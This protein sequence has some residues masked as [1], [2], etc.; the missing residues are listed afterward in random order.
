MILWACPFILLLF[1]FQ[2][3]G[4]DVQQLANDL[5]HPDVEVRMDAANALAD[6]GPDALPA[7][8]ALIETLEDE[9]SYVR[10]FSAGAISQIGSKA[11]PAI[12][13]LRNAL[14]DPD[15]AVSMSAQTALGA[16]G[17]ASVEAVP[18]LIE[19]LRTWKSSVQSC[20]AAFALIGIGEGSIPHLE[21]MIAWEKNK[22]LKAVWCLG[23]I[24][25]VSKASLDALKIGL[26]HENQKV[27]EST[28]SV[29]RTLGPPALTIFQQG[30]KSKKSAVRK[31]SAW[32]LGKMGKEAKPLLV[33]LKTMGKW[34]KS[35]NVRS[36]ANWAIVMIQGKK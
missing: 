27:C 8:S 34:D 24:K 21:N 13:A 35:A 4:Q 7:L 16:I 20:P 29:L 26:N 17:P 33:Q 25:S 32:A 1:L 5:K 22:A 6:L 30:L 2:T 36:A 28:A 10:N 3:N 18:Q 12:P 14:K 23:Q 19:F 31:N 9:N 11:E 15:E